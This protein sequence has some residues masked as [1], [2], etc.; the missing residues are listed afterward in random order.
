MGRFNHLK[1]RQ[2]D[3]A[4]APF[5]EIPGADPP[6][7][8]WIRAIREASGMSIRQL[9]ERMGVS[10]TT[11]ATLERNEA[12]ETVKLSSLRAVGEA[13]GC[14]LVYALVPH[15][16]LEDWVRQRARVVAE[17]AV[18]RVSQSMNLEDQAIPVEE[19]ERQI[20][21]LTERLW[22]EMPRGLWDDPL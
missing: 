3:S 4:L 19:E 5:R 21:E 14:E 9:A 17:R 10:K 13:L 2:V 18:G 22:Q 1:I 20:S 8:G 15:T 11:A 12:A 6:H 7:A 16:S